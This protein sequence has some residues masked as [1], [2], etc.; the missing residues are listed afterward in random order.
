MIEP[1][2][3]LYYRNLRQMFMTEGWKT[4]IED[5][6]VNAEMVNS[7]E[8]SKDIEDLY[9]RKGQLLV[10]SNILNLENQIDIAEKQQLESDD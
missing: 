6:K 4:F 9:T 7:I 10:M 1:E 2:L 5:V 8:F 3:E